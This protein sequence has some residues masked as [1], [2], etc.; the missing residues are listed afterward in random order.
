MNAKRYRPCIALLSAFPISVSSLSVAMEGWHNYKLMLQFWRNA[1]HAG[2]C[3]RIR[4]PTEEILQ[5][6]CQ[7][8]CKQID[9]QWTHSC[10]DTLKDSLVQHPIGPVFHHSGFLVCYCVQ[11]TAIDLGAPL[12]GLW[13][14]HSHSSLTILFILGD[15]VPPRLLMQATDVMLSIFSRIVIPCLSLAKDLTANMPRHWQAPALMLVI[16]VL[17]SHAFHIYSDSF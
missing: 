16:E 15:T 17:Q 1:S 11:H 5:L 13:R 2:Y 3:L 10:L 14:H 6:C 7:S 9:G 4:S 12:G 8:R